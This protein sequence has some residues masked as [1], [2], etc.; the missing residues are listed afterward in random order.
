MSD[1][2]PPEIMQQMIDEYLASQ[3]EGAPMLTGEQQN[4]YGNMP[5]YNLEGDPYTLTSQLNQLQDVNQLLADPVM[6]GLG[7]VGSFSPQAFQPTVSM[8]VVD[9][10]E[11][12]RWQN[13]LNTPD[14]FE[15]MIAAELEGGGTPYSA[16]RK[17]QKRI[18]DNPEGALAQELMMN[19]GKQ[20]EET[21][22]TE[23]DWPSINQAATGIDEMRSQIPQLGNSGFTMEDGSVVS[24]GGEI[25]EVMGPNGPQLVRRTE[26]PSPLQEKFTELG[27]PNPYEEYTAESF[28]G[29]EWGQERADLESQRGNYDVMNQ[30]AMDAMRQWQQYQEPQQQP[31]QTQVAEE[32]PATERPVVEPSG[33]VIASS[34]TTDT[35]SGPVAVYAPPEDASRGLL[36]ALSLGPDQVVDYIKMHH[37]EFTPEELDAVMDQAVQVASSGDLAWSEAAQQLEPYVGANIANRGGGGESPQWMQDLFFGPEG[38][39][40]DQ[41]RL[42]DEAQQ[43]VGG[44]Q[45]GIFDEDNAPFV[46]GE[47]GGG[48]Q[49]MQRRLTPEQ[50]LMAQ[51]KTPANARRLAKARGSRLRTQGDEPTPPPITTIDQLLGTQPELP[52]LDPNA[53]VMDAVGGQGPVA[54]TPPPRQDIDTTLNY[55]LGRDA[56]PGEYVYGGGYQPQSRQEWEA[57]Q[58]IHQAGATPY[59]ELNYPLGHGINPGDRGAPPQ[60]PYNPLAPQEG[61]T[62]E[63][64]VTAGGQ[65][66]TQEW[67]PEWTQQGPPPQPEYNP[68]A[69]P[70]QPPLWTTAGGQGV[71]QEF[72]VGQPGTGYATNGQ[73]TPEEIANIFPQGTGAITSENYGGGPRQPSAQQRNQILGQAHDWRTNPQAGEP[74]GYEGTVQGPNFMSPDDFAGGG[75][76]P[77]YVYSGGYRAPA[78][79][80]PQHVRPARPGLPEDMQ[81][82]ATYEA[83]MERARTQQAQAGS[84]ARPQRNAPTPEDQRAQDLYDQMV[85]RLTTGERPEE[86]R[87]DPLSSAGTGE[88][89]RRTEADRRRL[90]RKNAPKGLEGEGYNL[91]GTASRR[92][93]LHGGFRAKLLAANRERVRFG[94]ERQRIYGA[95]YGHAMRQLYEAQ[96]AG[97]SPLQQ[98]YAQRM[99]NIQQA[100]IN[101]NAGPRP[102]QY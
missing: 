24:G 60:P 40:N 35:G 28:M 62:Y 39:F 13:Y 79:P 80:T 45:T 52:P 17:I 36:M 48:G 5:S 22:E 7:G 10:P 98:A 54:P 43:E 4:F 27:L 1:A 77:P 65:T 70:N 82:Q 47:G 101:I 46:P 86:E 93:Q 58:A 55:P 20:N 97:A 38:N 29:P 75:A 51:A 66:V 92:E 57:I 19:F 18:T 96:L 8:E 67:S 34:S 73:L 87:Y 99:Q 83:M 91:L 12:V 41:D 88:H 68:L 56:Q 61:A 9:S 95:D 74:G 3:E 15:G 76:T 90:A 33:Q 63:P 94:Q 6:Q 84:Q 42:P 69:P 59:A 50:L 21:F 81:A 78:T 14:S 102:I 72:Q 85:E 44:G 26:E 11:Y 89:V 30:A 37:N 53:P 100:G 25:M 64:R 31:T 49:M 32:E 16:I 23:I 71:T 2:I